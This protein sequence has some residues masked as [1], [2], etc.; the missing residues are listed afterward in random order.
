M[1]GGI[2]LFSAVGFQKISADMQLCLVTML[3]RIF[4]LQMLFV[5]FSFRFADMLLSN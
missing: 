4:L 1:V 3:S 2:D 5:N